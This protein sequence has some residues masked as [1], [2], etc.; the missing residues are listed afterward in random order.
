M[1]FF[2]Y[3]G[4]GNDF[5]LIDNREG[6]ISEERKPD[7]GRQLCN[8]RF[9][10]GG[11][12]LMLVETSSKADSK[13]RIFNPDGSEPG[14]CGNGIRCV[15]KYVYDNIIKK[16]E[17]AIETLAGVKNVRLYKEKETTYVRV[18]MGRPLFERKD[19]PATGED[20][21]LREKIEVDG[22]E[23]EIYAVNTGVPHVIIFVEDIKR[24]DVINIGRA[25]RNHS[26][27]PEGTNVNF[28]EI[29]RANLFK[30]RTYERG[31]EDETLACG[32]GITAAGV[33]GVIVGEA[34]PEEPIEI[35]AKGGTVYIEAE[36][37]DTEIETA[38]MRG[39][40]EFVFEGE[41]DV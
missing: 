9:G 7:L 36:M 26:L 2:K 37:K 32:T 16:D 33:I 17:I 18:N 28:L 11:D 40:V 8:R 21:L 25:V 5:V 27:F 20:R 24:T 34:D 4:A 1:N 13:M 23:F 39:P 14:M 12:G 10:I 15:A 3:H 29:V 35:V 6:K 30:I 19:I 38:F 41:I 31:V 22:R